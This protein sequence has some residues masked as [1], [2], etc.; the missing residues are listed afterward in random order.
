M[1]AFDHR[2]V[3][4]DPTPDA[5]SSFA[6]RKRLFGLQRSSWADYNRS[7]ISAGGG[8]WPRTAKAIPVS[9]PMRAALGLADDVDVAHAR[10][11]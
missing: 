11:S 6:E 3:F 5:A 4:V 9:A 10:S 1:A 2:H 7:R 8:V